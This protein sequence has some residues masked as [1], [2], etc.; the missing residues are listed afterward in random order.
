VRGRLLSL[1]VFAL[2]ACSDTR[3][4]S[5]TDVAAFGAAYGQ[6]P[7][8][9]RVGRGGGP[10]R[11]Y[12]Y[13]RLD[14]L[15][16]TST[17]SVG[18][19]AR[20][21]GFDPENGLYAYVDRAGVPGW[22]DLRVGTVKPSRAS[23]LTVLTSSNDAWSIFGVTKDT[24]IHRSTPSGEWE[25]KV[26][27]R[28]TGLFPGADGG[29]IVLTSSDAT[30]TLR[31]LR[32]PERSVLDSATV[33]TPTI[34]AMS[35]LGDRLYMAFDRE[36]AALNTSTFDEA[37]RVRF[38]GP[39][40]ALTTTPSGDRV[41]VATERSR[42]I[43]ILDRYSGESSDEIRLPGTAR[44]LRM[45]P[46]GRLLLVRPDTGDSVWVI[47]VG[48]NRRVTTLPTPWR[49]DL[50]NVAPDGAVA[51]VVGRDV[52][53]TV[54]GHDRPRIIVRDG[55]QET[56]HFVF[57]NGFRPRAPG[58]DLPVVFPVDTLY[59]AE[60]VADSLA[61]VVPTPVDTAPTRPQ[62]VVPADTT[63][64]A[65]PVARIWSVQVAAV[66]SEDRAREI[67][68]AIRVDGA[69]PRVVIATVDGTRVYRVVMGPFSSRDEADRVGR[70]SG[71]D[72][73]VFEGVP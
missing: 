42:D 21:I 25:L 72:Y 61:P 52:H 6:D 33:P 68:R 59:Y 62:Q 31:R 22:V 15:I 24:L 73:W 49:D 20:V 66:L 55:A 35:P 7:I 3:G 51:T 27:E 36:V 50:P 28:V 39:V 1:A 67:A 38:D 5:G 34:T 23:K 63:S 54:P 10:V 57:W 4:S 64:R 47:D 58:L 16:W 46:L 26:P 37:A 2:A 13:P 19:Q 45:D 17:Q 60:P 53:F 30:S 70:Q 44:G 43:A 41:F 29:L 14:S 56:W 69:T 48:T 40:I 8:A 11:A 65:A 32:P 9:L 12:Q 18:A 71:R